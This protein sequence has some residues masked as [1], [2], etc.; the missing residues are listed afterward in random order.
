ME[1]LQM[2]ESE[3]EMRRDKDLLFEKLKTLYQ[4][5]K[6]VSDELIEKVTGMQRDQIDQDL[7]KWKK[8]EWNESNRKN[9]DTLVRSIKD[10]YDYKEENIL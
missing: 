4:R 7:E 8:G 10:K 2:A 3:N 5:K 6:E 9:L 1:L